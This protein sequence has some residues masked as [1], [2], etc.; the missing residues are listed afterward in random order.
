M[1]LFFLKPYT[2]ETLL[3]F[4]YRVA[5]E[6]EMTNLDWIFELILRELSINLKP[7]EVN[8][9]K[10]DELKSV[11]KFLGITFEEAKN[12]TVCNYFE[13]FHIDVHSESKNTVFLY[14]KTRFCPLCLKDGVY[15]RKSWISRH[16][17]LCLD[18]N[19]ILVDSCNTCKNI[20][21]SKSVVQDKC[22]YCNNKLS[23]SPFKEKF[24]Y[25]FIEYQQVLNQ[26]LEQNSLL[27]SHPWIEDPGTYV[28]TL[29]YLALWI[30]KMIPEDDISLPEYGM[31]FSKKVLERNHLKNYRSIEQAASLYNFVYKI[32]NNW[33]SEFYKF[34]RRAEK[35]NDDSYK[36]FVKYGIKRIINTPLWPISMS[37]TNYLA[38]EK[39]NLPGNQY[40]RSDEI[41]FLFQN[42]NGGIINSSQVKS[43]KISIFNSEINVIDKDELEDF[44]N[45]FENSY[46]KE[47]LRSLWGTSSKS[48]FAILNDELIDGAFCFKTDSAYNW[49]IPKSSILIFEKRLKKLST[50]N[51]S[52]PI[53]LNHAAEWIGPDKA[54]LLIRK[55][56]NST[57]KFV[58][59]HNI[60]DAL[61]D[62]KDIYYQIKEEI[63]KLSKKSKVISYRDATFILGVKQSDI[64]YWVDNNRF[65]KVNCNVNR[66]IPI[67]NFLDF[68]ERFITTLEL[69]FKLNIQIKQVNKRY[70]IGKLISISGPQFNDG[71]R[72]LFLRSHFE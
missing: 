61:L 1:L 47:E 57:L 37:F 4:I 69:A 52:T 71:K 11:A 50:T 34:L 64:Q 26:I 22:Q 53:S 7:E 36:S 63:I 55:M 43:K 29:D 8:W 62:K 56:L 28:Q 68:H 13:R 48:T 17:I 58:Y 45:Q 41:K 59:N 12:L 67:Q 2:Q 23:N 65:G 27:L 35:H 72:L 15:Q 38:K 46:T 40:V 19:V 20:Q 60:S 70:A 49:V 44:M 30:A 21:N 10:G 24:P 66:G 32:I 39:S 5:K 54:H 51:I 3:S 9:L 42:F 31:Y 25:S 6:H 18:H 33:P 16:S 14:K